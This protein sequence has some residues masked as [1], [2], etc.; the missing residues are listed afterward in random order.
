MEEDSR[1]KGSVFGQSVLQV[2]FRRDCQV[3]VR[4]AIVNICLVPVLLNP[5]VPASLVHRCTGLHRIRHWLVDERHSLH[6][7]RYQADM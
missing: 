5:H 2:S 4:P 3:F 1:C 6:N 7:R